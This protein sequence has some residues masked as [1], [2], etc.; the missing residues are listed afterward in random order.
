MCNSITTENCCPNTI[1]GANQM[2]VGHSA[3]PAHFLNA[4]KITRRLLSSMDRPIT[5]ALTDEV[6]VLKQQQQN[7]TFTETHPQMCYR[8]VTLSGMQEV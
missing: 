3:V 2:E 8:F 5:Y 7:R 1:G 6:E 4:N